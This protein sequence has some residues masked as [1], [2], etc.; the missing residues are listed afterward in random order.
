LNKS[1]ADL[2]NDFPAK[3]KNKNRDKRCTKTETLLLQK[4]RFCSILIS[5]KIMAKVIMASLTYGK[6]IYGKCN[7]GKCFM[8]NVFMAK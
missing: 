2:F 5:W 7:N 4:R 6:S 3:N 1:F 8:A